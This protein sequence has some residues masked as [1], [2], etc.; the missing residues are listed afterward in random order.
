[1]GCKRVNVY[2]DGSRNVQVLN[3]TNKKEEHSQEALHEKRKDRELVP[4]RRL[5]LLCCMNTG[6]SKMH[7][8]VNK[9]YIGMREVVTQ[10][11]KSGEC[12]SSQ[13]EATSCLISLALR[14]V[15]LINRK[16]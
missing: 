16:L 1:M 5:V 7:V 6:C 13:D 12:T 15:A 9:D 3:F 2:R 10:F 4:K 11:G 8:T 14:S